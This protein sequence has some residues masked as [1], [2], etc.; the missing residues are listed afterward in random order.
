VNTNILEENATIFRIKLCR[1]SVRSD[2]ILLGLAS[3]VILGSGSHVTLALDSGSTDSI[4][5]NARKNPWKGARKW[6]PAY[7]KGW[8]LRTE[9]LPVIPIGPDWAPWI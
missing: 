3:T 9:S 7:V 2:K 1:N 5:Y 4:G 6:N 8:R